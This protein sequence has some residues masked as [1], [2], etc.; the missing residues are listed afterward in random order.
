MSFNVVYASAKLLI[1][2]KLTG[3]IQASYLKNI[4]FR[5]LKR[6]DKTKFKTKSLY[7]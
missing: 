5:S 3:H 2:I 4:L 1:L 7:N 6:D